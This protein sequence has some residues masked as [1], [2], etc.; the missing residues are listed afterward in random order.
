[1]SFIQEKNGPRS[2]S[3]VSF[4]ICLFPHTCTLLLSPPF[5]FVLGF[6]TCRLLQS[7]IRLLGHQHTF[8]RLYHENRYEPI[9]ALL[10]LTTIQFER[11][12]R[13]TK[14][15]LRRF[16]ETFLSE[17]DKEQCFCVSLHIPIGNTIEPRRA[18]MEG[19]GCRATALQVCKTKNRR[20]D[21]VLSTEPISGTC[22]HY[23]TSH[24]FDVWLYKAHL[25]AWQGRQLW[26]FDSASSTRNRQTSSNE[27]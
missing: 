19:P 9:S 25:R 22:R 24:I 2:R 21:R 18:H 8:N 3:K 10:I 12:D 15:W 1:M 6:A 17:F 4:E 13:T 5:R 7:S 20:S 23:A 14:T 11:R 16:G 27:W 26:A